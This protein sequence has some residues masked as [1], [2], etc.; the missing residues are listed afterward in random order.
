MDRS[1]CISTANERA[2]IDA[3]RDLVLRLMKNS[4][5]PPFHFGKSL[6]ERQKI[7]NGSVPSYRSGVL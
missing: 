2:G 5:F 6:R 4:V 3:R 7:R 1:S